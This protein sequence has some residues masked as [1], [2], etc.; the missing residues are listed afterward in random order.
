MSRLLLEHFF[1]CGDFF[2]SYTSQGQYTWGVSHIMQHTQTATTLNVSQADKQLGFQDVCNMVI[3]LN[4][5]CSSSCWRIWTQYCLP[6]NF[7][8]LNCL[9]LFDLFSTMQSQVWVPPWNCGCYG[10]GCKVCIVT[11]ATRYVLPTIVD[12]LVIEPP[13]RTMRL[14]WVHCQATFPLRRQRLRDVSPH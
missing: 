14:C 10:W 7:C 8:L 3:V 13:N 9:Q 2:P 1:F 12:L 6:L 5:H 4:H 11:T